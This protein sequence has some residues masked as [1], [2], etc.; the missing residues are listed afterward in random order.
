LPLGL[1]SCAQHFLLGDL[2]FITLGSEVSVPKYRKRNSSTHTHTRAHSHTRAHTHARTLTHTCICARAHTR[3]HAH[4]T[5]AHANTRTHTRTRTH[6]AH[7]HT[8]TPHVRTHAHHI[9][10]HTHTLTP[11][12]T[13]THAR[14]RANY[15]NQGNPQILKGRNAERCRS[16]MGAAHLRG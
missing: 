5:R 2:N 1:L 4:H 15:N 13:H 12:R 14:T 8:R 10:A 7:A 9:H 3:S 11:A 16:N 6:T